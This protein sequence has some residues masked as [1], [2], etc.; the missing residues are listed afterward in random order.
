MYLPSEEKF[1]EDEGKE[2]GKL[3]KSKTSEKH[4]A[5]LSHWQCGKYLELSVFF[6]LVLLLG[7]PLILTLLYLS[8]VQLETFYSNSV[9][10]S[11]FWNAHNK[12]FKASLPR[13]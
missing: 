3:K 4:K 7:L 9:P 6:Q 8:F 13:D 12:V 11:D 1:L 5:E 2:G 10:K